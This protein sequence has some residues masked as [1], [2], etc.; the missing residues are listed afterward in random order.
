MLVSDVHKNTHRQGR[1]QYLCLISGCSK[2]YS[3]S[4]VSSSIDDAVVVVVMV[5]LLLLT[6]AGAC[7]QGLRKH[8]NSAHAASSQQ[9]HPQDDEEEEGED[10]PHHPL[11]TMA[12]ATSPSPSQLQPPSREQQLRE[13]LVKLSRRHKS[14]VSV[15]RR[16]STCPPIIS[17]TAEAQQ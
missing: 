10:G 12:S 9:Q 7:S 14:K 13:R 2:V 6:G 4:K 16:T 17:P 11:F 1:Q 3:T 8:I 5:V 15:A